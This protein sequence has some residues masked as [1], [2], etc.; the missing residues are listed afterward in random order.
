MKIVNREFHRNYEEVEKLEAG[1]VLSGYEVK[2]VR[3]SAIKL[4]DAYV[5]I[6]DGEAYLVN[7]DIPLYQ[8]ARPQGYDPRHRRK[9]L[10]HKKELIRWQTKIQGGGN[11]T[12]APISCYTK[13]RRVKL[14]IALA[15]GRTDLQKRKLEK[16]RDVKRE[17]KREAREYMKY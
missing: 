11:L 16:A 10:L 15:R 6:M 17:Q 5:K 12:I 9:L 8:F 3:N 2:S 1:V 7:A 14:E 4:D 13:G